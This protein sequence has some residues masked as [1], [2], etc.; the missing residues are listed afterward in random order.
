MNV[1]QRSV[2]ESIAEKDRCCRTIVESLRDCYLVKK[3]I[4]DHYQNV[5]DLV[6]QFT[7]NHAMDDAL[8][9]VARSH[10]NVLYV[11]HDRLHG[12]LVNLQDYPESKVEPEVFR[13]L[14]N[15][16]LWERRYIRQDITDTTHRPPE[17][18][19]ATKAI[20]D[21]V[22]N[23]VGCEDVSEINLFTERFVNALVAEA[24]RA[25]KWR[26]HRDGGPLVVS[27]LDL[28]LEATW[29]GISNY[30]VH[31]R[32]C[33]M[34]EGMISFKE[35]E[36][37]ERQEII[38]YESSATVKQYIDFSEVHSLYQMRMALNSA[39][40]DFEG[41]GIKFVK[42]Q[43]YLEGSSERLGTLQFMP[44]HITHNYVKYAPSKGT[45]YV[46]EVVSA[47]GDF[48]FESMGGFIVPGFLNEDPKHF[49]E[50]TPK[51]RSM[52]DLFSLSCKWSE[53]ESRLIVAPNI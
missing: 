4:F 40:D 33:H 12:Q 23:N 47:T 19:V 35:F 30:Y 29:V 26:P 25:N 15:H 39:K 21:T 46:L 48:S 9:K 14:E 7:S 28:G 36:A 45:S 27:L 17:A 42:D 53:E 13:M 20:E 22:K 8:C 6:P 37:A 10:G 49:R 18:P 11:V 16:K 50:L 41:G 44:G 2:S 51:V 32:K 43:C 52:C 31:P 5:E 34:F 24:E 38:K 1:G 3:D